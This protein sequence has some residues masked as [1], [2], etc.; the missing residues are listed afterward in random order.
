MRMGKSEIISEDFNPTLLFHLKGFRTENEQNYHSHDFIEV[1]ILLSGCGQYRIDGKIYQVREGDV[2]FMNPGTKHQAIVTDKDRPMMEFFIAFTDFKLD[3]VE[4]GH[5]DLKERGPVIHLEGDQKYRL[6]KLAYSMDA[7]SGSRQIGK[8]V[9]MKSYLLQLV[10]LL[11]REME[12]P[13]WDKRDNLTVEPTN[14]KHVVEHILNYFEEHYSE[15][16]SLDSIACNMY[17]STFYI[18][19]IFKNETGDAPI[20]HL[21]NIRLEHARQILESGQES[22]VSEVA[23]Q[24]GYEDAYHFSKLFKKKYGVSPSRVKKEN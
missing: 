6:F 5:F 12:E 24:V 18:S 3:G 15:K 9:M 17:L 4:E 14:R 11:V 8:Y 1:M 13:G 22:S 2:L 20:R 7:E 21:I 16:I 23:A 19:K 10:L